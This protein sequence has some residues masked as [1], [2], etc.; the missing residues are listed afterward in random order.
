MTVRLLPA[1]VLACVVVLGLSL[2]ARAA[3]RELWRHPD[4]SFMKTN[5]ADWVEKGADGSRYYFK[6]QRRTEDYVLLYDSSR[7]CWVRLYNSRC[8]VKFGSGRY[9]DYYHGGW[10]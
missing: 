3:D 8:L 6:E 5:G 9:E 4:G 1:F 7:D 10:R 2:T